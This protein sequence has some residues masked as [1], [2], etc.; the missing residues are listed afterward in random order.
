MGW[1]WWMTTPT[2]LQLLQR[3]RSPSCL[4]LHKKPRPN[5]NYRCIII[6]II[7]PSLPPPPPTTTIP[8]RGAV[9]VRILVLALGV[10]Y[11]NFVPFLHF[12]SPPFPNFGYGHKLYCDGFVFKG[13]AWCAGGGAREAG[14]AP[15]GLEEEP[16]CWG[17]QPVW[18][19]TD[20]VWLNSFFGGV[21]S[22]FWCLDGFI[23]EKEK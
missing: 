10:R 12:F 17:P 19:G 14:P 5:N 7:L 22:F 11:F 2:P 1:W 9:V 20:L 15:V 23:V 6:I 16:G 21:F 13:G 18:K 3:T 4:L 8:L